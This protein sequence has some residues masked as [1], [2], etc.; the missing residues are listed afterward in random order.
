MLAVSVFNHCFPT[1]IRPKCKK[2]FSPASQ[3]QHDMQAVAREAT[4]IEYKAYLLRI[5][6]LAVLDLR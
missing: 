3:F 6:I 5:S 2:P 4:L 1:G